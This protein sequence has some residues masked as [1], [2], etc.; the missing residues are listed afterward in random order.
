MSAT[1]LSALNVGGVPIF[2]GGKGLVAYRKVYFVSEHTGGSDGNSGLSVDQAF[3]TVQKALDT[4]SDEDTIVVLRG[5][6]DEALTTGQFPGRQSV[7]DTAVAGRGRWCQ[8]VGASMAQWAYDSPQLYNVSGSTATLLVRA[9]GWRVSGFRLV[10]DTG[11]PIIAQVEM[12]Q[13]ASTADTNWAPGCT[14]DNNV[15]YGAVASCRGL[16]IIDAPSTRV[17]NNIFELFPTAGLPGISNTGGAVAPPGRCSFIGNQFIDC[18]ENIDLA[19]NNSVIA[20][21]FIGANKENTLTRGIELDAGN[22]NIVTRNFLGGTYSIAGGY[23]S[24]TGDSWV[25]NFATAGTG[26]TGGITTTTPA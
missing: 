20:D 10:G 6:Y 21:N 11:S 16:N 26:V 24:A 9:E 5:S 7:L 17:L 13:S 12:A 3:S 4:V 15:F 22:N 14:F 1:N 8:L 25:G 19:M 18:A 23:T 2:G